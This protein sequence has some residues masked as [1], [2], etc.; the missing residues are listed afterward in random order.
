MKKIFGYILVVIL[1]VCIGCND[2]DN[3]RLPEIK[4][5]AEGTVKDNEGNEYGWV[6]YAGLDDQQFQGGRTLL[7]TKKS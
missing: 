4:P 2:D 3:N 6:R 1:S 7:R 5:E